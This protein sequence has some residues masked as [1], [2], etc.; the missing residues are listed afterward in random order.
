M[1]NEGVDDVCHQNPPPCLNSGPSGSMP[2]LSSLINNYT[3]GSHYLSLITTSQP[4]YIA[5]VSGSMQGCTAS[6]CPANI[7]APN[8]VDRFEAAGLTWKAYFENQTLTRGCDINNSPEPYADIHNPF[9]SFQ[10]ILNNTSRC[11]NIYRANPNSCGALK[12][13]VLINDL[14]NASSVANFMWLTPNECNN[15]RSASV[16]T[17]GCTSEPSSA[18]LSAGDNYLKSVVPNVLNSNTFKNTKSAL[19]ITFDEGD[20]YCP[21][22]NTPTDCI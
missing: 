3:I 16:C 6:T 14:N 9:I 15:T 12:D 10:D 11:S 18:C 2:Y 13:C 22:N 17:N 1:E 7:T 20:G 19:F 21:V 5:L 8:L 4:N